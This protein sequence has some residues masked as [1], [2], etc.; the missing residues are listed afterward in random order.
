ML[1]VS[2]M[3][4]H[5]TSPRNKSITGSELT[6]CAL[7]LC[8]VS[9]ASR[10]LS[11]RSLTLQSFPLDRELSRTC[12]RRLRPSQVYIESRYWTSRNCNRLVQ[13][14]RRFEVFQLFG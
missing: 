9:I 13:R 5:A 4:S 8:I 2:T 10:S 6:C 1:N 3:P 11:M 7:H 12:L 14:D